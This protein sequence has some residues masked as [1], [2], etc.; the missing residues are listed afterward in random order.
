M[1]KT[2]KMQGNVMVSAGEARGGREDLQGGSGTG[3][4]SRT[5]GKDRDPRAERGGAATIS[6]LNPPYPQRRPPGYEGSGVRF[7]I[8]TLQLWVPVLWAGGSVSWATGGGARGGQGEAD[9]PSPTARLSQCAADPRE[10][11]GERGRRGQGRTAGPGCPRRPRGREFPSPGPG[12]VRKAC[13]S[14]GADACRS[15]PAAAPA[16]AGRPGGALLPGMTTTTLPKG[17]VCQRA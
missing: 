6:H 5:P 16:T 17:R 1:I 8:T 3:G 4:E 2:A 13:G 11:R 10:T 15:V 7:Q 14:L 12:R 9:R